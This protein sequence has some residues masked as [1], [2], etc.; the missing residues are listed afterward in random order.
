MGITDK[1]CPIPFPTVKHHEDGGSKATSLTPRYL[2]A[3]CG[4]LPLLGWAYT[5]CGRRVDVIRF[6]EAELGC[7]L[8]GDN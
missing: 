6:R 3:R 1:L 5:N 4:F 7:L 2:T 8:Q